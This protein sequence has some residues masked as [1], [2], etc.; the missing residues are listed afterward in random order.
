MRVPFFFAVVLLLLA[1]RTAL[2]QA[3]EGEGEGE[4]ALGEGEGEGA[5][6][7]GEGEGGCDPSCSGTTLSFCDPAPTT[8]NC[9]ADGDVPGATACADI[10]GWGADC[11]LGAGAACDPG[12]AFGKSRCGADLACL[13]GT[14]T[15][16][17]PQAPAPLTPSP[18]THATATTVTNTN[19]FSC[20]GCGQS[21]PSG[22]LMFGGL[23]LALRRR[24]ER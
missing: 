9:A 12:Y 13:A 4:G 23:L 14:C 19:P 8:L 6:G 15:V 16:G 10:P 1:A 18:G 3:G 7:E 20:L 5:L 21:T 2:A 22:A 24:R 11:V 17:A